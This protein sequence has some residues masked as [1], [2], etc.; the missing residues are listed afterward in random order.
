MA[1]PCGAGEIAGA[2]LFLYGVIRFFLEFLRGDP[3]RE[4]LLGGVL[5]LA[6]LLSMAA[7]LIGG[8]LWLR[9]QPHPQPTVQ[10]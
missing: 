10:H 1:Q 4:P 2:W 9:R 3:A 6:Q 7:V 5:T 8:A